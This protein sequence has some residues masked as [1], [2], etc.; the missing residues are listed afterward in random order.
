[1]E[2]LL[3]PNVAY[4]VLV[5]GLLLAILALFSPGTGFLELGAFLALLLAG[6]SIIYLPINGW[7]LV[8]LALGVFPFLL[9]VRKSGR[10][11]FL[12]ASILALVIGS[13]FLF[14]TETGGPAISPALA[15]V[16]SVITTLFLWIVAR[17]S[18]E[19]IE[20]RPMHDLDTLI[21]SV[22][23]TRTQVREEGSV[24]VDGE[25]WSAH[26]R[27]PIPPNTPVRVIRR[28]GLILEVEKADAVDGSAPGGQAAEK[29]PPLAETTDQIE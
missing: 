28:D 7:A 19:A 3:N 8:I 12:L 1:M 9:A 22:G 21:G 2:I 27:T 20:I 24:Y 13:V 10:G 11:I 25:N 4:L 16:V 23:V 15:T 17:K 14:R 18:L 5:A 29:K 26:S 6:Y